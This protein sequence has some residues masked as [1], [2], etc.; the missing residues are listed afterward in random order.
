MVA[1]SARVLDCP[2]PLCGP[3]YVIR[4]VARWYILP[5][6]PL[7]YPAQT[8]TLSGANRYVIRRESFQ[9]NMSVTW[10]VKRVG[11]NRMGYFSMVF[12]EG[13]R[14]TVLAKG[15]IPV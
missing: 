6:F 1:V 4:R 14:S 5:K 13:I 15:T 11:L 9:V 2:G 3:R 7:R 8:A 10:L 12:G